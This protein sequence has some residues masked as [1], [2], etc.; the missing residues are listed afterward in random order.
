MSAATPTLRPLLERLR[1]GWRATP[2]PGFFA[3]WGGELHALLPQRWRAALADGA[4]WHLLQ[5]VEGDWRLRRAGQAEPLARWSDRLDAAAQQAALAAAWQG[6]DPEDR[7]LAL[8]LP[9]GAVLR[10]V[11]QLPLA[12]RGKLHQVAAYEM[13]RQTPFSAAQVHYAV[14]ELA[15]PA[16]PGRCAVE[17][18]AVRRDTLDPLL[19]RLVALGIT[20]DA[21]DLPQGDGRLG[22]NLLPPEQAPHRTR[23]R[24][25]LNLALAA[26]CALLLLFAMGSWLH[27]RESALAQMQAQVD[28]MH[29]EAQRVAALRRQLQDDAGA[30]GFLVQRKAQ[31]ATVLGVL[32]DLTRR[33]PAT[34]WLERFSLD[35]NGQVGFQGQS[36][37]AAK[38]LDLLKGSPLIDNANFQGSIQ[39]DPS[40]GKERF[41]MVAQLHKAAPSRGSASQP[42]DA[43]SAP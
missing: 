14:R 41:Y 34:A 4:V 40:T 6:T 42:A 38:L 32:L 3:W 26:G 39:S 25:R 10:R 24:L 18:L 5:A 37:Q 31:R 28:E 27:N 33:L 13:D 7:R 20:V 35:D 9:A 29:G 1:Q 16:A 43:G 36:P 21:V 11:L 22:V 19:A 17:L 30:A 8:L 2:L 12:A 15:Q 23:P